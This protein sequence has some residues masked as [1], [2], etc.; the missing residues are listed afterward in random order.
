MRSRPDGGNGRACVSAAGAD[1]RVGPPHRSF[2]NCFY[3]AY[4]SSEITL[5][6]TLW[7]LSRERLKNEE[8]SC[9]SCDLSPRSSTFCL[10]R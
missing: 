10:S 3:C 9:F 4:R 8:T 6:A 5:S 1:T 7:H 2:C